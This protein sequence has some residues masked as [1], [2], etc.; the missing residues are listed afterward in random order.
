MSRTQYLVTASI[1]MLLAPLAI[2]ASASSAESSIAI[3]KDSSQPVDHVHMDPRS[4]SSSPPTAYERIVFSDV[5][6]TLVHY[7]SHRRRMAEAEDAADESIIIHLPPSKTGA[8]GVI[9]ARTLSLCHRLRHG[10]DVGGDGGGGGRI[11]NGGVPFVLVS[12]MRTTTLFQ[13]LPYLPR[14]DA[15]VSESGG[16]IFYPRPIIPKSEEEDG[17]GD[18]F[19]GGIDVAVADSGGGGSSVEGVVVRPVSYPDMPPSDAVPFGL[20]EDAHWRELM[21]GRNSAGPDGYD[22]DIPIGRRRGRLWESARSLSGRGYVLDADGYATS[23]RINRKQQTSDESIAGFDA[24]VAAER[25]DGVGGRDGA[26]SIFDDLGCSTNLGCV[27]VYPA[28][29]GK[30]NCAEYLLRKFLCGGGGVGG[31]GGGGGEEEEE[32]AG[33]YREG[34][35]GGGQRSV[36]LKTHAYCMCDD[37]NDIEMAV[38]CRAA[39]LPSVTSES[40][41]ALAAND[42]GDDS[43]SMIVA[44]DASKGII[45]SLATE[46]A[47]E[48][49]IGELSTDHIQE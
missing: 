13:R 7:P 32:G 38:A 4:S 10:R 18:E 19:Y 28:M 45:E 2:D 17:D 34:E 29:S 36:S 40:M 49:I 42:D 8:R 22:D 20:V 41:R 44:E 33:E 9:S 39:Y 46:A 3:N 5:D 15:Y 11:V 30:R 12:G 35:A 23:F 6:G 25:A 37:D 31:G 14:A 43:Y 48:A 1:V 47:L 21:S 26:M 16:R 27:D 24:F